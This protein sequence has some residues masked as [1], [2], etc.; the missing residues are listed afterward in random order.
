MEGRVTANV[1]LA[2]VVAVSLVALAGVSLNPA[3]AR[4]EANCLAAPGAQAPAGR[5][6]FYRID[7]PQQRKCWYL[8]AQGA[9]EATAKVPPKP[10]VHIA[11]AAP[12]V[13]SPAG[14]DQLVPAIRLEPYADEPASAAADNR[15]APP[16]IQDNALM[17]HR[18][19]ADSVAGPAAPASIVSDAAAAPSL[20]PSDG[21]SGRSAQS[22]DEESIRRAHGVRATAAKS[23]TNAYDAAEADKQPVDPI[24]MEASG[25]VSP[26]TFLFAGAMLFI[27]GI[28]LHPIVQIFARRPVLGAGRAAPAWTT[29]FVGERKMPGFLARWRGAR[30]D[31]GEYHLDEI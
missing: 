14:S 24:P 5:H 31:R 8:R 16:S 22:I 7:R 9:A 23:D 11:S 25:R 30:V 20:R 12:E 18:A 3:D 6:W 17:A 19:D 27:A 1:G 26:L 28:F 15:T 29:S 21:R 4:A 10:R 13:R 2:P